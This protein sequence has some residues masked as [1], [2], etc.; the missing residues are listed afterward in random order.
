MPFDLIYVDNGAH[1]AVRCVLETQAR[2]R[3][4]TLLGDGTYLAPNVARNIGLRAARTEYVL[5]TDNDVIFGESWLARL[6]ASADETGAAL[7][8]P[9]VCGE[10]PPFARVHCAGC[11][12]R[13]IPGDGG[14]RYTE[15]L[16]FAGERTAAVEGRLVRATAEVLE[17]HCLLARRALF[18][19]IGL[20]DEALLTGHEHVDLAWRTIAAGETLVFE[21][22]AR[23]SQL[24]PPPFPRDLRSL[25][26]LRRRWNAKDNRSTFDHFRR[27]WNIA[28]DEPKLITSLNW[29]DDRP[30]IVFR[31]LR[32]AFWRNGVRRARREWTRLVRR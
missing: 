14:N 2:Q 24:L 17:F 19:R 13:L 23:V 6:V 28:P 10:G 15:R 7:T 22:A 26:F 16:I 32:P 29:H 30:A 3:E 8:A 9:L 1:A 20:L 27:K 5:F 4:F 11:E 12:G 25:A 18:E 21:P 31:Y